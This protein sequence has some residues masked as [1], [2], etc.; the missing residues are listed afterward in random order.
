VEARLLDDA[1]EPVAEGEVG[2]L[3]VRT[4][5][6]MLGYL[7]DREAT[8][9]AIRDGWLHTGDLARRD[10][11]GFYTL[12]GR[13]SLAINVGGHKVFPDEVEAVLLGHPG[14]REVV[15]V[16]APDVARGEVVHAIVVPADPAPTAAALQRFCRARLAAHKVP[17]RIEFRGSLPRSPLGKVL[18]HRL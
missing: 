13:R 3:V 11:A 8:S 12:V 17:R 6:L 10:A 2:E 15:V 9:R 14:V 7:E 4:P 5:G 16:A 1:G 18:R